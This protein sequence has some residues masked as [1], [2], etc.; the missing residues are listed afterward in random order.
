MK[1]K[2]LKDFRVE[3]NIDYYC[4][5]CCSNNKVVAKNVSVNL[6]IRGENPQQIRYN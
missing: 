4:C 1:L 2:L 3:V 6:L 5:C